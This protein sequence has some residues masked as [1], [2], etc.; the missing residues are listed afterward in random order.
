MRTIAKER[1][2][3][4][5]NKKTQAQ[6]IMLETLEKIILQ[7]HFRHILL[8]FPLPSEFDITALLYKL[9]KRRNI[10]LYVPKIKGEE[11]DLIEFRLPLFKEKFSI[12]EPRG[13]VKKRA[14]LD[15]M[16]VP[17]L[18]WDKKMR[19]IGFGRGYYDRF[20]AKLSSKPYIIF[21][22]LLGLYVCQKITQ[23]FDVGADLI[24]VPSC[25]IRRKYNGMDMDK[26]YNL[27]YLYPS[28]FSCNL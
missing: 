9:K 23:D 20:Y 18:A 19:R 21:V 5:Q 10:C 8:Y 17:M 15:V 3:F 13:R 22:S 7:N 25:K 28:N 4:F 12:F 2:K 26:P 11:F 27:N 24:L 14:K 6:K 1:I 16:I